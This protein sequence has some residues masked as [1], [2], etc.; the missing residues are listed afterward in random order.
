MKVV[1]SIF[2][3]IFFAGIIQLNAQVK[4]NKKEKKETKVEKPES[5]ETM[6][7]EVE[8]R[9]EPVP[10]AAVY[11]EQEG[12]NSEVTPGNTENKTSEGK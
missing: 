5:E 3:L 9:G 10:G 8:T 7:S 6:E 11:I 12:N 2:V 1:V 4:E